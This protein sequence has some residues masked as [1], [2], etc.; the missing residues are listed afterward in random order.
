[1]R[2]DIVIGKGP[3]ARS[4]RLKLAALYD[5]RR[6]DTFGFGHCSIARALW[7]G[8]SFGLL[9]Y[10]CDEDRLSHAPQAML[11]VEAEKEGIMEMARRARGTPRVALRLLR[12]VRD[13]AQV[14]A[15][16]VITKECRQGSIGLIAS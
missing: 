5:C 8:L 10:R 12:R 7:R 4:I 9:R 1:M 13:F 11:K 16:G 6:N 3:S 15:D 2:L 14:R